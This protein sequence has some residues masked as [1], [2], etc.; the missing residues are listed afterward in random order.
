MF[1][2]IPKHLLN[3]WSN[4]IK[5]T[6]DQ[7]VAASYAV[8]YERHSLNE[9]N[10]RPHT[11]YVAQFRKQPW[12]VLG[13]SLCECS[14]NVKT[15]INTAPYRVSAVFSLCP[16]LNPPEVRQG[17]D[18][19]AK[20]NKNY[21]LPSCCKPLIL[22]PVLRSCRATST[23]AHGT[24]ISRDSFESAIFLHSPSCSR[25]QRGHN[26]YPCGLPAGKTRLDTHKSEKRVNI[27]VCAKTTKPARQQKPCWGAEVP[28]VFS[29]AKRGLLRSRMLWTSHKTRE[30]ECVHLRVRV[31][32]NEN[33]SRTSAA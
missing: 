28:V 6:Y 11:C 8:S 12:K 10:S 14:S 30:E 32:V 13:R 23:C 24:Q 2:P 18:C 7:H 22:I 29:S 5:K 26:R 31:E 15:A 16:L 3:V 9:R 19:W 21:Q 20:Q 33:W 1:N 25:T 17:H 27:C 4:A